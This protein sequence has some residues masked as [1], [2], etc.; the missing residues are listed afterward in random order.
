MSPA[1][2]IAYRSMDVAII[3]GLS[4]GDDEYAERMRERTL[5]NQIPWWKFW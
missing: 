4:E 1:G 3:K 5:S 2:K